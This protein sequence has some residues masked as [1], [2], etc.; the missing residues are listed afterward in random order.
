[1][2]EN[3]E[4]PFDPTDYIAPE[5]VWTYRGYNLKGAEFN[6]AMVHLFR[7]EVSRANVWR[8]R[9]D[10]TTN[11][12][13]LTT[14]AV[15]SIVF[16]EPS[17]HHS[18]IILNT[19]LVTLFLYIEARRYRYYELW[20]LR[21]RLLETDFFAAMLVPPFRPSEQ[22]A[23]KMAN[24]LL[25]P[26][27]P[28]SLW[29]ALGR[30]LRRNYL[31]IYTLLGLAWIFRIGLVPESVTSIE[32]F[33]NRAAIGDIPGWVVLSA[34]I[35]INGIMFVIGFGTF[36]MNNATGEILPHRARLTQ[37]KREGDTKF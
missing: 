23:G 30:R 31:W 1:M 2:T 32:E 10:A 25:Y 5:S 15:L 6:T 17:I 22:W 7:A 28:I 12:A 20:S 24:S 8:Q 36:Y 37:R 26:R 19:L 16:G 33:L 21:V 4:T 34:G 13:V 29:E 3:S 11:W 14:G 9:L 27:F 35:A 18:I